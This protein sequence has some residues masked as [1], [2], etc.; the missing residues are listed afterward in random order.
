MAAKDKSI[1][2]EIIGQENSSNPTTLDTTFKRIT[3]FYSQNSEVIKERKNIKFDTIIYLIG[4]GDDP[5][6]CSEV[7]F[8][9]KT[10]KEVFDIIKQILKEADF[11]ASTEKGAFKGKIILEGCHGAEPIPDDNTKNKAKNIDKNLLPNAFNVLIDSAKAQKNSFLVEILDLFKNNISK[12]I[13][14]PEA[15]IGAYLG[16]AFDTDDYSKTGYG[17]ASSSNPLT[18]KY[19]KHCGYKGEK[20]LSENIYDEYH[21]HIES[22]V[23]ANKIEFGCQ[24]NA[25]QQTSK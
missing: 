12:N 2:A 19:Q 25:N 10:P 5:M 15:E 21:S 20:S 13:I 11:N 14:A 23:F 7:G 3:D 8:A 24:S 18:I 22:R 4:H 9:D 17:K 16:S 6:I 1:Y